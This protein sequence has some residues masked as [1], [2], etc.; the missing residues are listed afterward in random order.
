MEK[1]I[2]V[3]F[4]EQASS[5]IEQIAIKSSTSKL[6]ASLLRAID[7]KI[8][9]L[10]INPFLGQ[11]MAYKLIPEDYKRQGIKNLYR[12]ELPQFWRMLYT[13]KGNN[14]EIIAFVLDIV[15]HKEYN[16]KFNYS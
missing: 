2:V 16:K 13:V 4:Y 9:L 3:K 15:N 11:K 14:V 6:E 7:A 1:R 12:V 10:K 5:V 8:D